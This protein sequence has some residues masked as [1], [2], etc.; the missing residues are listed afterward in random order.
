M[1]LSTDDAHANEY[2]F[3]ELPCP[4]LEGNLCSNYAH[5]PKT[6][7]SFPHLHKP[8]F[9]GRLFGVLSNY[10]TCP[11]VFNVYEK[12]KVKLWAHL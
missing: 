11:I 3:N 9:R 4:F 2:V 5:R 1:H 7:A 12:L 10:A 8:V 6:C